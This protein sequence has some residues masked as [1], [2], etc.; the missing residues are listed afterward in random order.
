MQTHLGPW[1]WKLH[2]SIQPQ[3]CGTLM[4]HQWSAGVL[5]D[6]VCFFL[7]GGR[8]DISRALEDVSPPPLLQCA[9]LCN[10]QIAN[11]MCLSVSRDGKRLKI[12]TYRYI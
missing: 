2:S 3:C 10:C 8:S 1:L 6:F 4:C 12:A 5:G 7:G 9:V 11:V